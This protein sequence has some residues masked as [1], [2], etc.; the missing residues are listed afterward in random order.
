MAEFTMTTRDICIGVLKNNDID[1]DDMTE[2]EIANTAAPLIFEDFDFETIE[3]TTSMETAYYN[4]FYTELPKQII[5]KFYM[6]EIGSETYG[7]FKYFL[8]QK[9]YEIMPKYNALL[10]NNYHLYDSTY[11]NTFYNMSAIETTTQ[12]ASELLNYKTKTGTINSTAD[13]SNTLTKTGSEETAIDGEESNTRSGSEKDASFGTYYTRDTNKVATDAGADY[14]GYNKE[15]FSNTPQDDLDGVESGDYLTTYKNN[16]THEAPMDHRSAVYMGTDPDGNNNPVYTQKTY[17]SVTD[18]VEYNDRTNTLS[19][20]NRKDTTE[21]DRDETQTFDT[22]DAENINKTQTK[23]GPDELIKM[24][25]AGIK[26]R[27]SIKNLF[28]E[29][30]KEVKPLWLLIY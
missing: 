25:E 22:K 15:Y 14:T 1:Y 10:R 17:N 13:N 9:L 16:V 30:I 6:Y 12:T 2:T 5:R 27:E 19:F 21:I 3:G 18:L 4:T 7:K 26:T 8:E 20:S 29:I 28:S 24:L 23:Q 11:L